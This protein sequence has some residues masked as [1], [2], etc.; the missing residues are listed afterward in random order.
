MSF[1]IWHAITV[2]KISP[3]QFLISP[4]LYPS[5]VED[6]HPAPEGPGA[7][8]AAGGGGASAGVAAP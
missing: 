3:A 5:Q 1:C 8:P 6:Q 4:S 2:L 7:P